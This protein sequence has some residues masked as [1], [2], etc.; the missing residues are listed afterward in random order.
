MVELLHELA[1]AGLLQLV[2]LNLHHL[3]L[4][5]GHDDDDDDGGEDCDNNH[6]NDGDDDGNYD[7]KSYFVQKNFGDENDYFSYTKLSMPIH[8][9]CIESLA[10]KV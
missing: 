4:P 10:L 6:N 7:E 8:D 2:L 1:K 3:L 9:K 5:P